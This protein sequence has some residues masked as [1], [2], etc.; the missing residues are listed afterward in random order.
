MV[1]AQGKEAASP[2]QEGGEG[3][4]QLESAGQNA[5]LGRVGRHPTVEELQCP[6][7]MESQP[8]EPGVCGKLLSRGETQK[9]LCCRN[10]PLMGHSRKETADRT[11]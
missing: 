9:G 5:K 3:G 4:K 7:G 6:Q 10:M 11:L 8:Q 2:K 1:K